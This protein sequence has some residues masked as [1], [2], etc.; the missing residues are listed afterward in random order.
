METQMGVED[1]VEK[2]IN[3]LLKATVILNRKFLDDEQLNR[4]E[5]FEVLRQIFDINVRDKEIRKLA[6]KNPSYYTKM[7]ENCYKRVEDQF[8][9]TEVSERLRMLYKQIINLHNNP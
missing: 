2:E 1:S 4:R 5:Q 3:N 6:G 9:W 8:R 7:K